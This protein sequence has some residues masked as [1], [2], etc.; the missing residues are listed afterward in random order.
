MPKKKRNFAVDAIKGLMILLIVLHH[1]QFFPFLRHGYLAVDVFFWISGYYLFNS[2]VCHKESAIQYTFRRVRSVF[3]PYLIALATASL[4]NYKYLLSFKSFDEFLAVIAPYSAF[5]TFTE[6]LGP[7]FHTVVILI[8]AWFL[9]VLII[10]GFLLYSFLEYDERLTTKVILPTCFILGFTYYFHNN[11]SLEF[12]SQKG[13]ISYAFLRGFLEMG[14]GIMLFQLIKEKRATLEKHSILVNCTSILSFFVFLGLLFTKETMD[15]YCILLIPAV[16][17][18][19]LMTG[20]WLELYYQSV[21]LKILP[22]LGALS[23]EIYLIHPPV[24]HIIHSGFKIL[25][26]PLSIWLRMP[27]CLIAILL[28]AVSLR[29]IC[30]RILKENR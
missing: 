17:T 5:L 1:G 2:F 15:V 8:G 27:A 16:L 20:S 9:S 14:G 19:C 22:F 25:H 12:F 29:W 28:A 11:P 23:L 30:G 18:G 10:G 6:T 7:P 26:L 4:L 21:R 24:L 13:A 3:L